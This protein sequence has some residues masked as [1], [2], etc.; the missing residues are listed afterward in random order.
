[1]AVPEQGHLFLKWPGAVQHPIRPPIG[2]AI[3]FE[4]AGAEPVEEFVDDGL[5]AAVA[6]GFDLDSQGLAFL[7]GEVGDRRAAG[8]KGAS[9]GS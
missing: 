6:G 4:R 8:G 2:H 7:L 3:S 5:Q 9:P 1:M